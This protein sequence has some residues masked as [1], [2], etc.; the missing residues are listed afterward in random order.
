MMALLLGL[1]SNATGVELSCG[2]VKEAAP[3]RRASEEEPTHFGAD[4]ELGAGWQE[5]IKG[6]VAFFLV[7]KLCRIALLIY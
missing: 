1:N 3:H 2:P 5:N 7:A 4:C 6:V